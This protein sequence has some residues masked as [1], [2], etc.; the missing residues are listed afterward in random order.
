MDV[1]CVS[2]LPA[3]SI[4]LDET[5]IYWS[6]AVTVGV[7]AV[8]LSNPGTLIVVSPSANVSFVIGL[9]PGLQPLACKT[10]CAAFQY[11]IYR[12]PRNSFYMP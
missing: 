7:F 1:Q 2:E 5:H 3:N 11:S 12:L 10:L 6:S 9:S 8:E 4:T